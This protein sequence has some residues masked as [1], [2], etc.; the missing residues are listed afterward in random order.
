MSNREFPESTGAPPKPLVVHLIPKLAVGG[1]T[2][3]TLYQASRTAALGYET[4]VV[5]G[6]EPCPEGT[7]HG[8]AERLGVRIEPLDSFR[9]SILTPLADRRTVDACCRL[10]GDRRPAVI[11]TH[12]GKGHVIGALLKARIPDAHL[13]HQVHGWSWR[14]PPDGIR[15]KLLIMA[16]RWACAKADIVGVVTTLDVRKGL[17]LGIGARGKY[18]LMRSGVD[19]AD[20]RPWTPRSRQRARDTLCIDDSARVISNVGRLA[21]QKAP[22]RLVDLAEK[23]HGRDDYRF[24]LVGGGQLEREMR[25]ELARRKLPRK[26]I[27]V[28]GHRDNVPELLAAMDLV[29]LLSNYEGLPRTLVEGLAT[30]L[31][32][33]A[34]A[35][36]GVNEVINSPTVGSLIPLEADAEETARI[37]SETIARSRMDV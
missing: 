13:V 24:V 27:L 14:E 12:G 33:A 2:K 8:M 5:A 25:Q 30:G 11:H 32:I 28:L 19:L 3:C 10:I 16:E 18:R 22:H 26:L 4:V 34:R 36:D 6:T 17:D 15:D 20:F 21:P 23:M 9:N 7:M 31:P 29:L 35:V 1:A 37:V